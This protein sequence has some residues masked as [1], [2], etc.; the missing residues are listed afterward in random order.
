LP[1][2][3]KAQVP[4]A[5]GAA[6]ASSAGLTFVP[7]L[8]LLVLAALVAPKLM[9]RLDAAPASLRP[10]LFACALERPG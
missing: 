7:F 1:S 4:A 3:R 2:P 9:R 10:S 5:G 6:A 8:A